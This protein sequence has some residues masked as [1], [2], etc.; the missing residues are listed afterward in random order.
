MRSQIQAMILEMME[1]NPLVTQ[2][3]IANELGVS[4]RYVAKI[5]EEL[6]EKELIKRIGASRYGGKWQVIKKN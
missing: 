1:R 5:I 4:R 2:Q 3:S 6:K